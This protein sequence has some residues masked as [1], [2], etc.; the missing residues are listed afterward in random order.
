MCNLGMQ[1]GFPPEL[2]E[3]AK[4]QAREI[5]IGCAKRRN[6]HSTSSCTICAPSSCSGKVN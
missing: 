3:T 1:H 6:R 4:N 2:W 5:M